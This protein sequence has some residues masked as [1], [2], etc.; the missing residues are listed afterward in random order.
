MSEPEVSEPLP[1]AWWALFV[2]LPVDKPYELA[3]LDTLRREPLSDS[4][5]ASLRAR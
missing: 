3:L 2:G 4:L 5:G 1:E